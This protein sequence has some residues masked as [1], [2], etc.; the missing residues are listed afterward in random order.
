MIPV[1][2]GE[3]NI[4]NSSIVYNGSKTGLANEN[5]KHDLVINNVSIIKDIDIKVGPV[6]DE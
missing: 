2:N 6:P 3:R 1:S 5:D 4:K